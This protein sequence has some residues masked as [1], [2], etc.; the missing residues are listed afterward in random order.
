[1][2]S[3]STGRGLA[4]VA[5][6]L[7]ST[8]ALAILLQDAIRSHVWT[9][10]HGLIPVLMGVQIL[11]A[12]LAIAALR[13]WRAASA[14]GFAL[15]AAVAT[16]GVL[17]T[18][19]GKQ[20]KIAAEQA[21]V[22]AS[23]NAARADL[24]RRLTA[25]TDML[26]TA[27]QRHAAEC[28]SGKGKRC[29]GIL[30]TVRVYEDAV[31]GTRAELERLGP[32]AA[33]ETRADKMAELI[34]VLA[35]RDRASVRSAL[36][37]L[38]PFTFATIFELAALVSFGFA[39]G[40]KR[41]VTVADRMQT[42]FAGTAP[43]AMFSGEQPDPTPPKPRKRKPLPA[44]VIQLPARATHPVIA[45][46]EKVSGPVN[47]RE[48]A[49]LMSVTDGEA[50]KRVREVASLVDVCRQGREVLISLRQPSAA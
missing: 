42:S 14:L 43:V 36:L 20:S 25:N 17:Y 50:S 5:G 13:Q 19:V 6:T 23:L 7:A 10:E 4:L 3:H 18:S 49:R 1:M 39:F 34:A 12:H 8:G 35:G 45:A 31:G 24:V 16:W 41:R 33:T 28:A 30:A 2:D 15:V 9:L 32:P 46:L 48:L 21:V 29:E 38:E 11:T 47:N 27:R 40:G 26:D 22:A 37:L 44:N